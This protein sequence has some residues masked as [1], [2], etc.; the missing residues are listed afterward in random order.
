MSTSIFKW[1]PQLL[2]YSAKQQ[3]STIISTFENGMEQRRQR[4]Q[5]PIGSWTFNYSASLMSPT[6]MSK[7]GDEILA[8]FNDT[9]GAYDNFFL[10]SWELEF[11]SSSVVH[12]ASSIDFG[13][14]SPSPESLGFSGTLGAQGNY[15]Y[16]CDHYYMQPEQTT[17]HEIV[18]IQSIEGQVVNL[19]T[20]IS[21]EY[22]G[23]TAKIQKAHLVRFVNDTL[24]RS[25][26]FPYLWESPI[27][28]IE[29]VGAL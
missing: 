17:V 24:E 20:S 14:N 4:Y 12:D 23:N 19:A 11:N 27:E 18:R 25:H 28:F 29:D 22:S 1:M 16:I 26:K 10:P 3:Y 7:I 9:K 15:M 2:D 21:G 13:V 6:T 5:R 8:F